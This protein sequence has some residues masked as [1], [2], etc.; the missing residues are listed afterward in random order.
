MPQSLSK[1]YAHII[2]STKHRIPIIDDEIE[3]SL[4]RYLGS[5]CQA[6]ECY[7]IQVGGYL[8]HV[9]ILC[10]LSPKI[11]QSELLAEVKRQSSKWAKTQ[12]EQYSRFYWQN[13]FTV[14]SVSPGKKDVV[15]N[16]IKNQ[17]QHHQRN[18]YRSEILAFLK[19]MKMKYNLKY[20][21]D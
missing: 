1:M 5:I 21:W 4:F 19:K 13:G 18:S 15:A 8:D 2:F 12:G 9:H 14:F 16:Y 17:K 11:S 20:L 3:E 7:P 10:R 6:Y